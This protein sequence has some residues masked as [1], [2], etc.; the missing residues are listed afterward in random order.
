MVATC[1]AMEAVYGAGE[2]RTLGHVAQLLQTTF[3]RSMQSLAVH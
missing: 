2:T 3:M 1:L